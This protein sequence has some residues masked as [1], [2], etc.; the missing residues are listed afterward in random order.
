MFEF[1]WTQQLDWPNLIGGAVLAFLVSVITWLATGIYGYFVTAKDLPYRIWGRWYSAEF[2]LKSSTSGEGTDSER[3]GNNT[4]LCVRIEP[5]LGRTVVVRA[6]KPIASL[7]HAVPTKWV[8][9]AR[10]VQGDTLVGTW[11]STI[12]NTNRHGTAILKF[13]DYGRAV[14]YWTG[15]AGEGLPVYGYWIMSR[16]DKDIEMLARTALADAEF[17]LIDIASVVNKI[18]PPMPSQSAGL[19]T[20]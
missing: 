19:Q 4:F 15:L 14:G 6:L 3:S 11:R 12:K 1:S 5:R 17:R 20:A 18:P 10:L 13:L 2:D 9:R 7:P 8:V 16:D